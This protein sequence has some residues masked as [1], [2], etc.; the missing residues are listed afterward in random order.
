MARDTEH[1]GEVGERMDWAVFEE[2]SALA[3]YNCQ[4]LWKLLHS[5]FTLCAIHRGGAEWKYRQ[6]HFEVSP[7]TVYVCEPG[8]IHV[9]TQAHCPGDFTVLFI[10]DERMTRAAKELELPGAPHFPALGVPSIRICELFDDLRASIAVTGQVTGEVLDQKVAQITAAI[11][12]NGESETKKTAFGKDLAA[13]ARKELLSRFHADPSCTVRLAPIAEE[14]DV[15]YHQLIHSFTK[16]YSAAPYE[17][18]S[19]KRAEYAFTLL[20]QGP[21]GGCEN[22]TDLAVKC[23]YSDLAHMSR[24]FKRHWQTSPSQLARGIRPAWLKRR[25]RR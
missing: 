25:R 19:L 11:L 13:R 3:G 1:A 8:E 15:S 24:A 16:Q 12:A 9:T 21:V 23:G 5:N 6:R 2:G 4:H 14:L 10:D 17:M 18:I 20:R 7:G 22:L